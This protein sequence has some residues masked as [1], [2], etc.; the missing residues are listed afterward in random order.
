[1][2]FIIRCL[3]GLVREA[4]QKISTFFLSLPLCL[5]L[6]FFT[7]TMACFYIN[8]P[9]ICFSPPMFCNP[10]FKIDTENQGKSPYDKLLKRSKLKMLKK[11]KEA[12][13]MFLEVNRFL[14]CLSNCRITIIIHI[15]IISIIIVISVVIAMINKFSS[16]SN[17]RNMNI[18]NVLWNYWSIEQQLRLRRWVW[19]FKLPRGN[20]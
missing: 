5:D 14:T 2:S 8:S 12:K 10:L 7:P 19:Y 4:F 13:R 20:F 3:K 16:C 9:T 11:E 6:Q 15:N 1:M 17:I 18:L